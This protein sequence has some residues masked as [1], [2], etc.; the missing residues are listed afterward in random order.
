[1]YNLAPVHLSC[2]LLSRCVAVFV[3]HR[4]CALAPTYKLPTRPNASVA[5]A[6]A[7]GIDSTR[8][9]VDDA[10]SSS[11]VAEEVVP[12]DSDADPEADALAIGRQGLL[13][14]IM[15]D[16]ATNDKNADR[17]WIKNVGNNHCYMKQLKLS[18]DF[19]PALCHQQRSAARR[20]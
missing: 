20:P 17:P 14:G 18:E 16:G 3:D 11:A 5:N 8:V 12:E 2:I 19:F 6:A 15:E 4:K 10:A 9:I 13:S 7:E 1:M